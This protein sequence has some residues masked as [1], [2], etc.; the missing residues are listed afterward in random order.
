LSKKRINIYLTQETIKEADR[1]AREL[2]FKVDKTLNRSNILEIALWY[3]S[4]D[5][6]QLDQKQLKSILEE[7]KEN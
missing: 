3:L 2:A 4:K 6:D 1:L 7:E 5:V